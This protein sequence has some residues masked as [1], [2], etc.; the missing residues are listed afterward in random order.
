V[1]ANIFLFGRGALGG[2]NRGVANGIRVAAANVAALAKRCALGLLPA[3]R[4]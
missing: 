2:L 1:G 4:G 3:L